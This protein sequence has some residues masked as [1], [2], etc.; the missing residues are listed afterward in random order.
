MGSK[1]YPHSFLGLQIRLLFKLHGFWRQIHMHKLKQSRTKF[2]FFFFF[3]REKLFNL[4]HSSSFN[5]RSHGKLLLN[6]DSNGGTA[7]YT[8]VGEHNAI[9][10]LIKIIMGFNFFCL[11]SSLK[12][13]QALGPRMIGMFSM[14]LLYF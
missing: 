9:N 2:F 11:N 12:K 4:H 3:F 5:I 6:P 10:N 14:L 7:M 13:C 8:N 1:P